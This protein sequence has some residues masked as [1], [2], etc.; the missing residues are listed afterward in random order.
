MRSA[1]LRQ[2]NESQARNTRTPQKRQPT[3][4]R[5]RFPERTFQGIKSVLTVATMEYANATNIHVDRLIHSSA[6]R[7]IRWVVV[8]AAF[9]AVSYTMPPMA[10]ALSP[11]TEL[12]DRRPELNRRSPAQ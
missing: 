2:C 3:T 5:A 11:K 6:M 1:A 9:F 8:A 7:S 12:I 10:V 4:V